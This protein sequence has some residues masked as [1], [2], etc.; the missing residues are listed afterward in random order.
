MQNYVKES[1]SQKMATKCKNKQKA[2][3]GKMVTKYAK[4]NKG[5]FVA[6]LAKKYAISGFY[7]N[8]HQRCKIK[9]NAE[10]CQNGYKI[11]KIKQKSSLWQ[12]WAKKYA[13]GKNAELCK[14]QFVGEMST[15]YAKLNRKQF[16]AKLS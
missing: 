16:M 13:I 4:L 5:Q 7:K 10:F 1:L 2:V 3:C 15:K 14:R 8:S 9:Q 6:K 11:C 12:K